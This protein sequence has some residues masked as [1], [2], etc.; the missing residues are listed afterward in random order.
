[1]WTVR[2]QRHHK[3]EHDFAAFFQYTGEI[4]I[5]AK[6]LQDAP[7]LGAR[8]RRKAPQ[9]T[10]LLKGLEYLRFLFFVLFIVGISALANAAAGSTTST[11]CG[12]PTTYLIVSWGPL[13]W[14]SS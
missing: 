9:Y 10:G 8:M 3:E 2:S 1:M 5:D 12:G 4:P 6:R 13:D 14:S 11:C 7:G